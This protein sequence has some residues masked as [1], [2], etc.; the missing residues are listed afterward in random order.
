MA[1][2]ELLSPSLLTIGSESILNVEKLLRSLHMRCEAPE[3]MTHFRAAVAASA[4][5][6]QRGKAVSQKELQSSVV[7]RA[8]LAVALFTYHHSCICLQEMQSTVMWPGSLNR[9]QMRSSLFPPS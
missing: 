4:P 2:T 7:A 9:K 5:A 3:S 6:A 1:V 8:P